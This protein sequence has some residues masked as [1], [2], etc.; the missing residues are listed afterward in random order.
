MATAS[1]T[2]SK[3]PQASKLGKSSS[4]PRS[5]TRAEAGKPRDYLTPDEVDKLMAAARGVGRH[6]LRDATIILLMF[7]H[8]LRISEAVAMR[9]DDIDLQHGRIHVRRLKG[10]DDGVHPLRGPELRALR[11]V[12]RDYP[13]GTYLFVTERGGPVT[14]ATVRKMIARAGRLAG[15]GFT[16]NPHMLR[17]ACGYK[18]ANDGVDTRTLQQYL[19]H[20]NIQ[21][22]VRYTKLA[23]GRFNGLW[24]D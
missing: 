19:G 2:S 4:P 24:Q 10:S 1:G 3:A 7:R 22:T 18:L 9:W 16:V 12:K 21:N 5:R 6:G 15:F 23:A 20:T 13:Q 8:G 17:H 11:R 14:D